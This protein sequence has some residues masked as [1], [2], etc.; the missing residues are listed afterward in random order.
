MALLTRF[1]ASAFWSIQATAACLPA[2][3]FAAGCRAAAWANK[4][5]ASKGMSPPMKRLHTVADL[6]QRGA[7]GFELRLSDQHVVGVVGR[8]REDRNSRLGKRLEHGHQNP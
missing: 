7:R 3:G 1:S 5:A 6:A 4:R 2:S 8:D